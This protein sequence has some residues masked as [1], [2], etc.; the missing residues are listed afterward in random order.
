MAYA[1]PAQS[2]PYDLKGKSCKISSRVYCCGDHRGGPTFNGAISCGKKAALE[3][4][5]DEIASN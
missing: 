1:Q 5:R 2:L 4:V 3:V